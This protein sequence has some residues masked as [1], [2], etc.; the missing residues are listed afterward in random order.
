M[1]TE[2]NIRIDVGIKRVIINNDSNRIIEFNP[3]D[4]E[5]AERFYQLIEDFDTK[6]NDFE[7]QA[8]KFVN[9]KGLHKEDIPD[10]MKERFAFMREVCIFI[11]DRIDNLFGEGTSQIAF[12]NATN[13]D[14]FVQFFNGLTP[15]FNDAR[16]KKIAKYIDKTPKKVMK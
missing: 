16:T 4:I 2:S 9:I 11:K 13:F 7:E 3:S 14:M 15:I 6:M 12:G 10:D 8:K 5:F 1:N